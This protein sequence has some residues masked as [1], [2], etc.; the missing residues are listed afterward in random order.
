MEGGKRM[1]AA[2]PDATPPAKRPGHPG[3]PMATPEFVDIDDFNE[4]DF[5][6]DDMAGPAMPDDLDDAA[7]VDLGAAGRNW[8]R[9]PVAPVNPGTDALGAALAHPVYHRHCCLQ[10][11][12]GGCMAQAAQHGLCRAMLGACIQLTTPTMRSPL[13]CHL[14]GAAVFQQLE[15]DYTH[16]RPRTDIA[17]TGAREVPVVRMF[18]TN[19]AGAE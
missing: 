3:A 14:P 5:M 15:V 17:E 1:P 6:E 8:L 18:G 2:Q 11:W 13:L 7:A 12:G 10:G 19:D 9:P 16:G 4:E